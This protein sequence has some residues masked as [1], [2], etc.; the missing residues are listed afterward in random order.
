MFSLTSLIRLYVFFLYHLSA[1]NRLIRCLFSQ[2]LVRLNHLG[3]IMSP[4]SINKALDVIGEDYDLK[5]HEWKDKISSYMIQKKDAVKE[6]G[7]LELQKEELTEQLIS[8]GDVHDRLLQI[9][10]ATIAMDNKILKLEEQC[11]NSFNVVLDNIDIKVLASDMTSN[12]QNKD[13]HW[14]NHNAISIG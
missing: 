14:C 13:Y 10:A 8:G 5:L 7:R 9:Q 2:A 4:K 11:P 6:K 1:V 3:I 12:N